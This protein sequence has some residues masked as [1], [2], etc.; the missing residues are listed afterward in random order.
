M[1]IYYYEF[2]CFVLYICADIVDEG[3][4]LITCVYI[5]IYIY[6]FIIDFFIFYFYVGADIVEDYVNTDDPVPST[7]EALPLA[8]T[9]DVT[10]SV[11]KKNF[12][13]QGI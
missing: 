9:F 6:V 3:V 4:C 1:C 5:C 7:N 10:N 12:I 2:S 13:P 8:Y 11:L